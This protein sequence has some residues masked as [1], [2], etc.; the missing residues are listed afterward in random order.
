LCRAIGASRRLA[1]CGSPCWNF[2]RNDLKVLRGLFAQT[3]GFMLVAYLLQ[4]WHS[5]PQNL[6]RLSLVLNIDVANWSSHWIPNEPHREVGPIQFVGCAVGIQQ[7]FLIPVGITSS[8]SR[9]ASLSSS[10]SF[11]VHDRRGG[12]LLGRYSQV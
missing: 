5:S 3:F 1:I 12:L 8:A 11:M 2:T 4:L 10:V 7:S 9:T 6:C